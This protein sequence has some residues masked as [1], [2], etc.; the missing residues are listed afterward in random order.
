MIIVPEILWLPLITFSFAASVTPG[1][2]NIML[3]ASGVNFGFNRTIPH[4]AGISIGFF[5]VFCC[6]ALGLHQLFNLL[7]AL[8]DI[9]RFLGIAYMLYLAWKIAN[10]GW[11]QAGNSQLKPLTFMQAALFQFVNA[12]VIMMC[13]SSIAVF[14]SAGDDFVLSALIIGLFFSLVNVPSVAIWAAFG[15]AIGTLLDTDHKLRMFNYVLSALTVASVAV[16][17]L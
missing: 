15:A 10:S 6:I 14:T 17:F 13:V 1:P 11:A 7:P 4:I 3:A 12:K 5:V 9:L 8:Q 16:F 2:N